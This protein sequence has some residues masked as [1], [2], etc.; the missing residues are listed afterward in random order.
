[1]S[2]LPMKMVAAWLN[3]Q[4]NVLKCSG[5]PTWRTLINALKAI[6]QNGIAKNVMDHCIKTK[7]ESR[8]FDEQ[9]SDLSTL[10]GK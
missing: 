1:M 2:P 6:D 7:S 9:G 3:R 5:E 4:E 10:K 8:R